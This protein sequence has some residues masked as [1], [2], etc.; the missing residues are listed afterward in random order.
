MARAS[1]D[2][3]GENMR[4]RCDHGTVGRADEAPAAQTKPPLGQLVSILQLSQ[5]ARR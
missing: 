2:R 1:I 4:A 3:F 5:G